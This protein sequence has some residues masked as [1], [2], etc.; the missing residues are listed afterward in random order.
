MF[1]IVRQTWKGGLHRGPLTLV[2]ARKGAAKTDARCRPARWRW[3]GQRAGL[4]GLGAAW[5]L[6]RHGLDHRHDT[7]LDWG[8]QGF[9]GRQDGGEVGGGGGDFFSP[10]PKLCPK[11]AGRR[12]ICRNGNSLKILVFANVFRLFSIIGPWGI[13]THDQGIMSPLL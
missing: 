12:F 10:H 2:L 5:G 8:G 3:S 4:D 13:R 1:A 11:T 7:G 6:L 9:P